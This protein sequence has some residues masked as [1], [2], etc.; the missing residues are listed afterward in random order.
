[1]TTQGPQGPVPEPECALLVTCVEC[2]EGFEVPLPIDRRAI[3]ILLAQRGWFLSVMSPPQHAPILMGAL[4]S[5]CAQKVYS[6]E[7]YKIADER[8]QLLLQAAQGR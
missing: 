4:C 5:P 7:I 2:G 1:M 3:A 6:S 8:R